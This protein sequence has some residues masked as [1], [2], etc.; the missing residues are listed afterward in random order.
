MYE[1]IS[2]I[3]LNI[4]VIS[5][6][7]D[8]SVRDLKD[9]ISKWAPSTTSP[10]TS[11]SSTQSLGPVVGDSEG[12]GSSLQLQLQDLTRRVAGSIEKDEIVEIARHTNTLTH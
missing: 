12:V 6:V 5:P 11:S 3:Y 4:F 1:T 10:S 2:F 8:M 9:I 7:T